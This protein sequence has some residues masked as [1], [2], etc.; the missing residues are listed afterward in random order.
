ML[1]NYTVMMFS[2]PRVSSQI[3]LE[4]VWCWWDMKDSPI[5]GSIDSP[6]GGIIFVGHFRIIFSVYLHM[7]F[8][9]GDRYR[10]GRH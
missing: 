7:C 3:Q 4:R 2:Y 1:S 9:G 5:N 6:L 10:A 8:F